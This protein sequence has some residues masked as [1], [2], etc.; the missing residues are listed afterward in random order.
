LLQ[1]DSAGR[2]T[3]AL[4]SAAQKKSEHAGTDSSASDAPTQ[5]PK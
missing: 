4:L 5:T 2:K 3:A 1:P